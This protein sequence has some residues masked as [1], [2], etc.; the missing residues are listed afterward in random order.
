MEKDLVKKFTRFLKE[1]NVYT[2][3]VNEFKSPLHKGIRVDWAYSEISQD[4]GLFK[5]VP[6]ES[7]KSYCRELI[8]PS[9]ALNFAFEWD[10]TKKGFDFWGALSNE[11]RREIKRYFN[12]V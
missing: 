6:N 12:K 8:K 11:W 2:S 5:G 3:F 1:R 9:E 10:K 7:F 4:T